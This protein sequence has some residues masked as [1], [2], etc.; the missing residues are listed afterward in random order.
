MQGAGL[1]V[2]VEW[3]S[4]VDEV[5]LSEK[6]QDAGMVVRPMRFYEP[7]EKQREFGSVVLGFGNAPLEAI[8]GNIKALSQHYYSLLNVTT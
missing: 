6:A 7:V 4:G 1:H 5:E 3:Q 8:P 2:T